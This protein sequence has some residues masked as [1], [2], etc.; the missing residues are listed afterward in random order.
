M[1]T[2]RRRRRV[3]AS[4]RSVPAPPASEEAVAP[5]LDLVE[6][7][8]AHLQ[9][10]LSAA[11]GDESLCAISRT[12]GPVPAA[13]HAEGRLAALMALRRSLQRGERLETSLTDQLDAWR[14][15]LDDVTVR[16]AGRDWQAYRAG[17]VDELEL[18]ADRLVGSGA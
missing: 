11:L 10:E 12:A 14:R 8:F 7:R 6:S 1:V 16:E 3:P 13:K 18:L 2:F 15:W 4:I 9:Q 5:G 17:G